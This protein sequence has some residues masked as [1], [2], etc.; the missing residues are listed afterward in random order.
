VVLVNQ[1]VVVGGGIGG[2]VA[3]LLLARIGVQVIL[4]ERVPE[5]KAVGAGILL[6]ANGLAVLYGLGFEAPLKQRGTVLTEGTIRDGSD[7]IMARARPP[8]FG[9]GLD[10][11]LAIRRSDLHEVLFDAVEYDPRVDL[12][13][14]AEAK[15]ASA[16]G[17]VSYQRGDAIEKIEGTDLVI[18]ADGIHSVIRGS[19]TFGTR[20]ESTGTRYVRG[21]T[22]TRPPELESVEAWTPLGI[23]GRAPIAEG[24][25]FFSSAKERVLADAVQRQ[26]INAFREAWAR[27]YPASQPILAGLQRFDELLVNDVV[28][29]HCDR[30]VDGKLVL[31]GDAAHAMAPNL[32]QGANSALLDAAVL[33][34]E[35]TQAESLELALR[36]YDAQRRPVV[37]K[38]QQTAHRIKGAAEMTNPMQR[39]ARDNAMRA[40]LGDPARA[41]RAAREV[42][43]EDPV[44]LLRTVRA[45]ADQA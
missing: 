35:L 19:G 15:D 39:W 4:L 43:Q 1:C 31:V 9:E 29:I 33:A 2:A 6:Q 5:P 41:E 36:R 28:E 40:L 44:W 30:F 42:Q 16:S 23:F 7:H 32:G 14:G 24:A 38:V 20:V 13:L 26:D 37:Q 27:A 3:A 11:F 21:L 34:Y 18:G 25:Y 45:L 12:R 17:S 22:P 8:D 10:H